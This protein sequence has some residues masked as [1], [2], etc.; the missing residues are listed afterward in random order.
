M[1]RPLSQA[2]DN[3]AATAQ[4]HIRNIA[5]VAHVDHGKTTLVDGMLRQ[6]GLFR[7]GAEV[8]DR[9]LDNNDLERE[10]GITILAKN[11]AIDYG[12]YR[13][14]ILDT[15]GHHD[16]GGEVERTLFM[17]DGVLLLVDAAEGPL[18]QTRFVLQKV[19]DLGLPSIV[20]INKIDRKDARPEAVLNEV[21]DL[22]IDL[23]ASDEAIEFPVVYTDG[24]SGIAHWELGDGA[25]NL[26]AL[27]EAIAEYVPAPQDPVDEPLQLHVNNLG[28][29]DYVGR[30]IIGRV[31]AGSIA[32]GQDVFIRDE[33]GAARP[34][35]V[36]RLY[37][38]K[39]L[40]RIEV[41]KVS[42]GDI[43]AMAGIENVQI[44]DTV[45]AD[46]QTPPLERVRVDEPTMVMN[47]CVNTSPFAGQDGRYVTSRNLRERLMREA[48]AN[49]AIRVEETETPDVFRVIGRG[50]LQFGVFVETMRREGYEVMLSRPEVVTHTD[51]NGKLFEPRER[52]FIDC[53]QEVMGAISERLGPRKAQLVE[54]TPEGERVRIE[55]LIPTRG[56]I[57]FNSEFLTLT[58]GEGIIASAFE[59]WI[60]WQ[61]PI[62]AR[63]TGALVSDRIGQTTPYALFHL[64]PRGTLFVGPGTR[65]YDGMVVG[66]NSRRNDINVNVCREKHLT[67]HRAA[68]RD[69]NVIL[70]PPRV[71]P[72][73]QAME[74]IDEDEFVEVTPKAIRIR[75]RI[76]DSKRRPQLWR[77]ES[78]RPATVA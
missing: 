34:G 42:A 46:P 47:F 24:R 26:R 29:D 25:T 62:P 3:A 37:G 4:D 55:Y 41:P 22:F 8:V 68:H 23:G 57:G 14:N 56:L 76:L 39:G 2:N 44:G 16:F 18:P 10:R 59:D 66:E 13:I 5:V 6:S 28:W 7:E 32:V 30:L 67:N 12:N 61:G 27:F 1:D 72:L 53:R 51:E 31:R 45:T 52:L 43:V 63:R 54:M 60:P 69:E 38:F 48:K 36:M 20:V 64:Q 75:K 65:V 21:Y 77:E 50:E 15:P 11:T 74:F 17:A 35:R 78:G 19:L 73:E 70:T 58:R 33:A 9:V 49:V 71:L 40:Q